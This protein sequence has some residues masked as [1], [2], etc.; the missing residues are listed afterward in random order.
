M[1]K[2]SNIQ[3]YGERANDGGE[4]KGMEMEMVA[5]CGES[6]IENL[7]LYIY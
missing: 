3:N 5:N 4:R 2:L 1:K 6:S 7:V